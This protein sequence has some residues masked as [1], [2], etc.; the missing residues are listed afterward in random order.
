VFGYDVSPDDE[1][2][3]MLQRSEFKTPELIL[4]QNFLEE[5]RARVP[6]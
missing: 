6:N 3:V 4:V 1:R 5:L 2:F